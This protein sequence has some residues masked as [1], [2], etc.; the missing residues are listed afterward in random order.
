MDPDEPGWQLIDDFF[1]A[2]ASGR[3]EP[4]VRRYGRVRDRLT[5]YLDTAE[6]SPWL[7]TAPATLLSAEREFHDRGA[8]WHLLGPDELVCVLPGFLLEPWL[9]ETLGEARTQ[10]SLVSRLLSHVS[11]QRLLDLAAVQ[12]ALWDAEAAVRQARSDLEARSAAREP[13]DWS[14]EMPQRFRQEPGPQW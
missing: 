10:I 1:A 12:C 9:P 14:Q 6:M 13:D 7:G 4:T 3:A 2:E 5:H 11:R 8:F